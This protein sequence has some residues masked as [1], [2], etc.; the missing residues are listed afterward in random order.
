MTLCLCG[1]AMVWSKGQGSYF[2]LGGLLP[3]S[4]AA[5]YYLGALSLV[6]RGTIDG[7]AARRPIGVLYFA[8]LLKLTG[9]NLQLTLILS[10]VLVAGSIFFVSRVVS[11]TWGI[12]AGLIMTIGLCRIA[13]GF[14]CSV[15]TEPPGLI[16]SSLAAGCFW[17]GIVRKRPGYYAWGLCLL[18]LALGIRSGAWLIVPFLLAY[19]GVVF[20][21][22]RQFNWRALGFGTGAVIVTFAV[23]P[24]MLSIVT[25]DRAGHFNGNFSHTLYGLVKGGKGWSSAG[26]DYCNEQKSLSDEA[27]CAFLYKVSGEEFKKHPW[28][29]AV[30]IGRGYVAVLKDPLLLF[31]PLTG[32]VPNRFRFLLLFC[33]ITSLV[34]TRRTTGSIGIFIAIFFIGTFLSAPFILDAISRALT[35]TSPFTILLYGAPAGIAVT[36]LAGNRSHNTCTRDPACEGYRAYTWALVPCLVIALALLVKMT[37]NKQFQS[38]PLPAEKPVFCDT[39]VFRASK[40]SFVALCADTGHTMI[41][42]I[43][44]SDFKRENPAI[45]EYG[46]LPVEPGS[47]MG[48]VFNMAGSSRNCTY[49]ILDANPS[50]WAGSIVKVPADH[51][52]G[53]FHIF[54]RGTIADDCSQ[55]SRF[56]PYGERSQ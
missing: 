11:T 42:R 32:A 23:S 12:T 35:V 36:S 18:V 33:A 49:L 43:R 17:I 7:F 55:P 25:K 56:S 8:L 40:G 19:G 4:D 47:H 24:V 3:Y 6:E 54:Y 16:C 52:T 29:L 2:S 30:G 53:T 27:F 10:T 1:L 15:M 48:T 20:R 38:V 28:N 34:I 13:Q 14:T 50:R 26:Y 22:K 31:H 37:S 46:D 45:I 5:G 39:V 51:I 9:Q 44:I 41:P 21:N